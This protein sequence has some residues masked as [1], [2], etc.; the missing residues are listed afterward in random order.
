MLSLTPSVWSGLDFDEHV[1]VKVPLFVFTSTNHSYSCRSRALN[2]AQL[3]QILLA[4]R[5]QDWSTYAVR[6]ALLPLNHLFRPCRQITE[7]SPPPMALQELLGDD[8]RRPPHSPL[9]HRQNGSWLRQR[10]GNKL[11]GLATR[12]RNLGHVVLGNSETT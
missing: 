7:L 10:I 12:S 1:F 3:F 2:S 4:D 5:C 9:P 8:R 11:R 6:P